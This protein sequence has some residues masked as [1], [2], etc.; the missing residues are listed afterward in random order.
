MNLFHKLVVDSELS[1]DDPNWNGFHSMRVYWWQMKGRRDI[2]IF[3]NETKMRK[4]KITKTDITETLNE[5]NY[6][7]YN[8]NRRKDPRYIYR[9]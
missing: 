8:K 1:H 7:T 2:K 6:N 9:T 3:L 5:Y 4:Y